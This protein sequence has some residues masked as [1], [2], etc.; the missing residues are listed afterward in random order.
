MA[1]LWR[2]LVQRCNEPNSVVLLREWHQPVPDLASLI[3]QFNGSPDILICG[4]SYG[5]QTAVNLA[6]A[7]QQRKIGVRQLVLTDAVFRPRWY[8][9]YKAFLPARRISIPTNVR[10]VRWFRQRV[11]WPAG[12]DLLAINP[13]RTKIAPAE[14]VIDRGHEAMDELPE[15]SRGGTAGGV[16][17]GSSTE[18]RRM[19]TLVVWLL[20]AA[21]TLLCSLK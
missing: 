13:V 17:T 2:K 18:D 10:W 12:H 15:F 20:L 8:E 14:V 1:R 3:A 21:P 4:Y 6:R 19:R 11:N 9:F 5:G 7:L 16:A